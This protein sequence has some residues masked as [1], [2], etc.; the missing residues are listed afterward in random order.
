MRLMSMIVLFVAGF[1]LAGWSA[2][3]T[4][5]A[6]PLEKRKLWTTSRFRC[7]PEPPMPFRAER[8]LPKIEFKSPTVITNAPDTD[9]FFVGEQKGMIYSVRND[10]AIEQPDLFL[11]TED[12]VRRLCAQTKEDLVLDAVYGL[13]FHPNFARNRYCYVCYVVGNREKKR[14]EQHPQGTRVSR[15]RV[16]RTDPPRCE[17]ESEQLVISWLQGGHNGGCLKFGPDGCLYISTGDG[18]NAFPPDGHNSGQ[19]VTNLLS[20][21][22]RIDVD[23]PQGEAPYT[24][25]S[26]NPFLSVPGARGEI[27]AFGLRNPWK[28]S[29][30]RVRGDLWAGDVGWELWELVYRVR[31]GDNYG[32]SLVEGRQPVHAERQRGPAPIVPPTIEIPHTDGVSVTGGFVYRGRKFPEL[33]G[34]YI[35]GDWETRRIWSAPADAASPIAYRE[36]MEPTVRVVDFS[37]DNQG[38]LYLLDYDDGGI[39]T[40]AR[41]TTAASDQEFPRR[42]SDTGIF[43]DVAANRPAP[44]VLPFSIN[45]E[46]WADGATAERLIG[47]PGA[48]TVHIHAKPRR[49]PGTSLNRSADF[50]DDTLFVKTLS[51]PVEAGGTTAMRR[52]ETQVLHFDGRTWRGYT[53]EWNDEQTDAVLVDTSGKSRVLTVADARAAEGKRQQTWRFASRTECLRCHNPRN[54]NLLA[55]TIPQ[56]NRDGDYGGIAVNQIYAFWE[57]GLFDEAQP[58]DTAA[59]HVR[60]SRNPDDLPRFADPYDTRADINDRGRTYLHVNCGHCHRRGGGGTAYVH[61][62]HELALSETGA[63]GVRPSQGTFGIHDAKIIAP[64]DPYRSVLYFRMAKLG[65][66][67][68]P[69]IGT[70]VLDSRGL[71][72]IHDWILQLSPRAEH[73]PPVVLPA[74]L[75]ESRAGARTRLIDEALANPSRAA[76]LFHALHGDEFSDSLRRSIVEAA[77]RHHDAAVRDLFESFLPEEQ[78]IKRLGDS[79]R[80]EELLQLAGD[81]SRGKALF[82]TTAGIQCRTCHKI[83]DDGTDL[84]PD[85]SRIATRNDRAKLLESILEPSKA[86]EPRFVTWVIE[87]T[88]GKVYSGLLVRRDANEFVIKDAQ[89]KMHQFNAADIETAVPQQKSL[90]PELL[91][92]DMTA[93]QVADLLAYLESLK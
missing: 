45:A 92:R 59:K 61:L 46:Q 14:G 80:P 56:L 84:G 76:M 53:Y 43:S 39:Y 65:P 64:G 54:E 16:S 85:L 73:A 47:V 77:V 6:P 69:H 49:V 20:S 15:L 93:Q 81:V 67:H 87:T 33:A 51:V 9:R 82:H 37:E 19:D 11:D 10:P 62:N 36:I 34:R 38:E 1:A 83:G 5:Q 3:R 12:L 55:F 72:L 7:T 74:S 70:G 88:A 23:H 4:T 75:E 21:I 60:P 31:K 17:P 78:R 90:M 8:V 79:I 66:G 26:D 48:G 42:L 13:T 22:L 25:P 27:W 63:L 57:I 52:V 40:L 68:M 24:I 35:F 89:N 58:D 71:A 50:P 91:L 30:D 44:G 29:F 41:N 86:I 2:L 32:W 18:G 28:M